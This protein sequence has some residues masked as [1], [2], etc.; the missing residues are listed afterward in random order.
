LIA[1]IAVSDAEKKAELSSKTASTANSVLVAMLS[2]QN[3]LNAG[4]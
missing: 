2:N 4:G 3:G 1:I